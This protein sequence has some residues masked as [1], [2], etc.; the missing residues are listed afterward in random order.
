MSSIQIFILILASIIII[1]C[2]FDRLCQTIVD[3]KK[4]DIFFDL[5][6][7]DYIDFHITKEHAEKICKYFDK[8]KN[9]VENI[10]ICIMLNRII[11]NLGG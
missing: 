9:E 7:T 3:V 10:E 2:I 5:K 8:D 11:N 6:S 4:K 1:Y